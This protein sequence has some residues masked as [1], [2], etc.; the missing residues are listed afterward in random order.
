MT[1]KNGAAQHMPSANHIPN[2]NSSKSKWEKRASFY[3]PV[4]K[5]R[6]CTFIS[7]SWT[8]CGPSPNCFCHMQQIFCTVPCIN[9]Y[10]TF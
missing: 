1:E 7:S 2:I 6:G 8:R 4:N 9:S 10:R 5:S 3:Q